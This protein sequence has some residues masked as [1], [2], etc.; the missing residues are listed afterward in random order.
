MMLNEQK[1]G[2]KTH[3]LTSSELKMMLKC[4]IT[5]ESVFYPIL[6]ADVVKNSEIRK[7]RTEDAAK[8]I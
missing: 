5:P 3:I 7:F 6:H 8:W 1:C 4:Q 2:L